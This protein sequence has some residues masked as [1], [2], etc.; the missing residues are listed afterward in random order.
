MSASYAF[1]SRLSPL[2]SADDLADIQVLVE[3][4]LDSSN[5]GRAESRGFQ[6]V[7]D[8]GVGR[9]L[10]GSHF[11]GPRRASY[12]AAESE[13]ITGMRAPAYSDR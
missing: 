8:I 13:L 10:L 1:R 5:V 3:L 7:G 2:A 4:L 12:W 6:F 9:G 11:R